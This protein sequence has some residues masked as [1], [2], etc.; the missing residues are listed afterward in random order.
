MDGLPR[1]SAPQWRQEVSV[2]PFS[3]SCPY[4][5]E[6][7]ELDI[8]ESGGSRQAFVQDCPVCCRPWQVKVFQNRDGGW[9]ATLRTSDE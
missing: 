8:D 7:V 2:E 5:G 4:C 3:L 6:S 9:Q 1:T